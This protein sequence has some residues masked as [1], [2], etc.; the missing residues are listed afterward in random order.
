MAERRPPPPCFGIPQ[1]SGSSKVKSRSILA[2]RAGMSL[3]F[4]SNTQGRSRPSW[5]WESAGL[6]THPCQLLRVAYSSS[7]RQFANSAVRSDSGA[8]RSHLP[9]PTRSNR[10]AQMECPA[11][12]TQN[13]ANHSIHHRQ[14]MEGDRQW[15]ACRR[16]GPPIE[17][18]AFPGAGSIPQRDTPAGGRGVGLRDQGE[19][20]G[21]QAR[22]ASFR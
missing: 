4:Q 13:G 17:Q 20:F 3:A 1:I 6:R 16:S 10:Y 8:N 9:M 12:R 21:A 5:E 22:G 11:K 7:M 18:S 19:A 2:S 15:L 14:A